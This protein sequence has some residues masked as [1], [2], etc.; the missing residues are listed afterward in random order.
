M[1]DISDTVNEAVERAS[2]SRLN[3]IIAALVAIT[4]SA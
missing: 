4:A 3:S 2:A 1:G